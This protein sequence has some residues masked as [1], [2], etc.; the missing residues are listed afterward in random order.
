ML[1]RSLCELSGDKI[2]LLRINDEYLSMTR[3]QLERIYSLGT[4]VR[5]LTTPANYQELLAL[6]RSAL[7][8]KGAA[9]G[10]YTRLGPDGAFHRYHV[11]ITYL[12]G[13]RIRSLFFIT[14]NPLEGSGCPSGG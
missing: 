9:E 4:D 14:Y 10:G 12:S 5:T 7:E 1:F 11:K 13:D 2:E 6:F 8:R 3:D